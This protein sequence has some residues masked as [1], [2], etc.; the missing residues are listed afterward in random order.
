MCYGDVGKSFDSFQS[1]K[2]SFFILLVISSIDYFRLHSTI[3]FLR[4][5][6][7][8]ITV[9]SGFVLTIE[10]PDPQNK[11]K[12]ETNAFKYKRSMKNQIIIPNPITKFLRYINQSIYKKVIPYFYFANS[13]NYFLFW[14]ILKYKKYKGNTTDC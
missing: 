3:N 10:Y 8:N 11:K 7:H 12:V 4:T 1:N 2:H 14:I 13:V 5:D 6:Y 9:E